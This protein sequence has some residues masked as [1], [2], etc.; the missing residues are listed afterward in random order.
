MYIVIQ[1]Q[2]PLAY[3]P[4]A[5]D[6]DA[7]IPKTT[8]VH[9]S[10]ESAQAEAQRLALEHPGR[11]YYVLQALQHCRTDEADPDPRWVILDTAA[12]LW[13]SCYPTALQHCHTDNADPEPRWAILDAAEPA[14]EV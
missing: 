7:C 4:Q 11:N 13:S 10:I 1:I 5:A 12:L 14:P 6:L 9:A 2:T 3:N 8:I